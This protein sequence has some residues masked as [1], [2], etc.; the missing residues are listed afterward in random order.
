MSDALQKW[1]ATDRWSTIRLAG[2]RDEEP[3]TIFDKII[4]GDIPAS[5]VKQ[6]ACILAFKDINP[7]APAHVLVIPKLR[8]GLTSLRRSSPDHIEVLGKM[9]VAAGEIAKD[10][11]LGFGDGARIV[12]NDGEVSIVVLCFIRIIFFR[13]FSM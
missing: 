7:V 9:L 10:A 5:I 4:Q 8:N 1:E 11:S 13:F 3:R 2:L 6:D 12:I